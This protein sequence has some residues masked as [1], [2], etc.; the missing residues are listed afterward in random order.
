MILRRAGKWLADLL[1]FAG[2]MFYWNLRKS[3]FAWRGR[4]GRCPCQNESDDSVP[5]RVRCDAMLHW[6]EPAR[7]Q[8]I[9]PLLVATPDGWR[10]SVHASQVRPFWGRVIRWCALFMVGLYLSGTVVMFIGLRM[11]GHAPVSWLQVAWPGKWHEIRGVQSGH[12][13]NKAIESFRQGRL[14][15][16]Y[17]AL[18][19]ARQRDPSNY[20]AT[21]LLAQITMFQRSYFHSDDL[22]AALW[23]EHPDNRLRTAVVY[24]DSLLALDRMGKLAESSI[25][26]VKADPGRS[27]VWVQSALL[28]IRSMSQAEAVE[29]GRNQEAALL[30]LAPHAVL[31]VRAELD[32]RTGGETRA[33]TA[34]RQRFDGPLNV[35]YTG[36]QIQRLAGL[37]A[38]N[39]AQQ[40]LDQQGPS[41]G[42]FDHLLTQVTLS[43]LAGDRWAAHGD[44]RALL[45]EPLNELRVE[46]LA[47]LLI[48]H[49]DVTL[50]REFHA[51]IRAEAKLESA[52]YG[53]ALWTAGIVCAASDEAK[54]WQTHGQQPPFA[55]Y[56]DI[57]SVN[58]S[59][60]NL[61]APDSPCHLIN[62]LS[63]P[64][65]VI[66]ALLW[67]MPPQAAP[68]SPRRS[69]S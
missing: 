37:G 46:R 15:E 41:M 6:H 31:L 62:V 60:R 48:K 2:A 18:S 38:V 49:P 42:K 45:K 4:T 34:L 67:R 30:A 53:A 24:H 61:A 22:F 35:F 36:Y 7:F 13:F 33:L 63:L 65:E 20:D 27:A 55:R 8:K 29:F 23:R 57:R 51:R 58:F 17:L 5:G 56:P 54:F 25:A 1:R 28:A 59:S 11:V 43:S 50:Y 16:A 64:R 14:A 32:L 68:V 52:V 26:M 44:F 21:L 69:R 40:L 10:C 3:A 66:M 47:G 9:C 39:E 19:T 12:L